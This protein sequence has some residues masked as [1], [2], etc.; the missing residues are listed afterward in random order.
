[1]IIGMENDGGQVHCNKNS[2]PIKIIERGGVY[3]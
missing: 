2:Q 3:M 1:M